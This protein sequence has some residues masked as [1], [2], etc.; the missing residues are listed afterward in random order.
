MA[1]D[2]HY[3]LR[4]PPALI[5]ELRAAADRDRMSIEA[6]IVEAVSEKVAALRA[7]GLLRTLTADEQF[8]YL[9]HRSARA[10]SSTMLDVIERAGTTHGMLPGDEVPDGWYSGDEGDDQQAPRSA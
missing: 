10:Q 4:I 7:K 3:A 2:G 9:A 5:D 1:A 6:F 8:A